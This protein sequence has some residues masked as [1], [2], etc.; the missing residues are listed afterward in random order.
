MHLGRNLAKSYVFRTV[1]SKLSPLPQKTFLSQKY[2]MKP[3]TKSRSQITKEVAVFTNALD[4]N[5]VSI[6]FGSQP[7]M[8]YPAY[9]FSLFSSVFPGE[10]WDVLQIHDS[11]LLYSSHHL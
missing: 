4:L 11:I 7:I 6:Q 3:Q 8:R 2:Y 9:D 10:Y 5:P 1:S